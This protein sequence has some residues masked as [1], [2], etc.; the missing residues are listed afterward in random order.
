MKKSI[1]LSCLMCMM[2]IGAKAQ[3][4]TLE[5]NPVYL[6]FTSTDYQN[7]CFDFA[8]WKRKK[9]F[10]TYVLTHDNTNNWTESQI[11]N[12][13]NAY[14][15]DGSNVK[16]ILFVGNSDFIPGHACSYHLSS[17]KYEDEQRTFYYYYGDDCTFKSDY[18]Y[19]CRGDTSQAPSIRCGRINVH[20]NAVVQNIF[21][22]IKAYEQ[23]PTTDNSFYK[24]FTSCAAFDAHGP[25]EWCHGYE[26]GRTI[27]ASENICNYL[28]TK[29]PNLKARKIYVHTALSMGYSPSIGYYNCDVFDDGTA[30][31]ASLQDSQLWTGDYNDIN[32]S[33]NAGTFLM[34]YLGNGTKTTWQ[35]R[36]IAFQSDVVLYSEAYMSD[37][38]NNNKYPVILSM[39]H[40]SGRYTESGMCLAE[41]FLNRQNAGAVAVIAPSDKTFSGFSEYLAEGFVN[42]IWPSPGINNLHP[43]GSSVTELGDILAASKDW[44]QY[45]KFYDINTHQPTFGT[46]RENSP[47][48]CNYIR[49]VYHLF[50]DPSMRIYTS[51]PSS[52]TT[53]SIQTGNDDGRITVNT[54]MSDT[55]ITFFSPILN[56]TYNLV[57]YNGNHAEHTWSDDDGDTIYVCVDKPNYVPYVRKISA[58]E[59][60]GIEGA[61][62]STLSHHQKFTHKDTHSTSTIENEINQGTSSGKLYDLQ[63]RRLDHEPQHGVFIRDGRKYVKDKRQ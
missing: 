34:T 4:S 45:M 10:R 43:M 51:N 39:S 50:G 11:L 33:I 38:H 27:R 49:D 40:N 42:A 22:K 62:G 15:A 56:N 1:I 32:D 7:A 48:Y 23:S 6:I 53:V 58:V 26:R 63:G 28:K 18:Y 17:H 36:E 54:G 47:E 37:L 12:A 24:T 25:Y 57:S 55:K 21:K 31:P 29:I 3:S 46:Y 14:E 20:D 61:R 8:D 13:I 41:S 19:E 52:F 30:F 44:V 35:N 16:Y 59:A 2:A 5:N 60:F 9:G